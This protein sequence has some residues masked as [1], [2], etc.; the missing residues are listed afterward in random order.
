MDFASAL[1]TEG[2]L[3]K[4]SPNMFKIYQT[5]YF[6]IRGKGE[7]LVWFKK[8]PTNPNQHPKGTSQLK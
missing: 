1:T 8:K 4:E 7:Y 2:P 6:A 5:R 3:E